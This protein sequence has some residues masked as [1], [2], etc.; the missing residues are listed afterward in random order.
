MSYRET[1]VYI[2]NLLAMRGLC[3]LGVLLVHSLGASD[4][5][6]RFYL[7]HGWE[8]GATSRQI[9]A[10]LTPTT[11]KNFVLF[12]FVHSGYLMGKI[13]FMDRYTLDRAGIMKFYRGRF[14][15]IAP[16]LYV[17]LLVCMLLLPSAQPTVLQTLG[18]YLF[19]NNYTGRGINGVT[20]SLS[21]EMQ[22]YL[23]APFVFMYFCVPSTKMLLRLLGLALF[24]GVLSILDIRKYP[25][26][27][28]TSYFMLGF[29][30]NLALRQ[31]DVR[32]FP[33]S[34]L[35]A[36]GGG[37]FI[38]NGLYYALFNAGLE[39]IANPLVGLA[40]A[41]TIFLLECPRADERAALPQDSYGTARLLTL[42]FWTWVGILSYGIYLW[43]FP[44]LSWIN[45]LAVAAARALFG[46]LGGVDSGWRRVLL[47]HAIQ[48]PMILGATLLVSLLTFLTVEIRFRPG[49]YSWDS[50]RYL[51]RYLRAR[52]DP[53]VAST[54]SKA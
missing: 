26:I 4:L 21:W 14:L 54:P 24:L 10:S 6:F 9:L 45:G 49:L 48:L 38:G 11:G 3:A 47:F 15:R 43:H 22:Y 20:W 29:A 28:F 25:P 52:F 2:D 8:F 1:P 32:K 23:I 16:L 19:F 36:V 34:T 17:N 53:R 5:S 46:L 30:L 50:S 44:L 51:G 13:F 42:R 7:E 39:P 40:A 27:E 12:F 33:G 35:L 37:F 18:D 41:L 31:W